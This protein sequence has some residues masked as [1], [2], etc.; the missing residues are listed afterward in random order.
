MN[1][2]QVK[3]LRYF[4]KYTGDIQLAAR[5]KQAWPH[6]DHKTKG[7][8]TKWMKKAIVTLMAIKDEKA[9]Y[10]ARKRAEQ[11]ANNLNILKGFA[12]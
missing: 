6:L 11:K 2:K 10:E 5:A 8:I 12:R 1:E 7:R 3:L 9:K 4:I